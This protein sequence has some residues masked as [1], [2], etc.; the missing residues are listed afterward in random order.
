MKLPTFR[1]ISVV[2]FSETR[3]YATTLA[4]EMML[5][6][7]QLLAYHFAGHLGPQA[8]SEYVLSR[9]GMYALTTIVMLGASIAVPRY[10]ALALADHDRKQAARYYGAGLAIAFGFCAA[11]STIMMVFRRQAAFAALG[12][13]SYSGLVLVTCYMLFGMVLHTMIFSYYRGC[14]KINTANVLQVFNVGIAPIAV[15]WFSKDVHRI[16]WLLG[17]WWI[18]V[19][20]VVSLVGTPLAEMVTFKRADLR[21]V[22]KFG[23]TRMPGD[24]IHTCL[25][26]APTLI[27]ARLSGVQDAGQVGFAV[28]CI[29][30]IV[31]AFIPIAS[32]ML[33]KVSGMLGK[34]AY[35]EIRR[36]VVAIALATLGLSCAATALMEVIAPVAI[37][38]Y[39]GP[40]YSHTSYFLR[41]AVIGAPGYCMFTVLRSFIDSYHL[42]AYNTKNLAIAAAVYVVFSGSA[43]Y[44]RHGSGS[45]LL[46]LS[47]ALTVLGIMTVLESWWTLRLMARDHLVQPK[48][49]EIAASAAN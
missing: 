20:V 33:P 39:L 19:S 16:L 30:L 8:F 11:L 28:M 7:L 10:M 12:D 44:L 46:G 4:S 23:W 2:L 48:M 17:T 36:H 6:V 13:S 35:K 43:I 14:F 49:S 38:I 22:L 5:F 9:R 37:R 31:R 25:I 1:R 41:L 34:G 40:G 21:T 24:I 32:V 18:V 45:V 15:F 42:K 47:V 29:V 26:S 27:V 3:V